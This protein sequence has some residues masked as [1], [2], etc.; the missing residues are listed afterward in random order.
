AGQ[1]WRAQR[2]A[3][4]VRGGGIVPRFPK[5]DTHCGGRWQNA[6]TAAQAPAPEPLTLEHHSAT[7]APGCGRMPPECPQQRPRRAG[8]L[9]IPTHDCVLSVRP[10]DV[11]ATAETGCVWLL[12]VS[13]SFPVATSH[14]L[15]VPSRLPE[16]SI[17]PSGV[18]TS[19]VTGSACP[20]NLTLSFP[21]A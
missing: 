1:G 14:N 10:S 11:R 3:R 16:M 21:V 20:P 8:G 18:N 9:A 17:L 5:G 15:S 13:R 7:P 19:E 6:V 4:P 2:S 12:R